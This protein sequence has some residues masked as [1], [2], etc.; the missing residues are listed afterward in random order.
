M[1]TAWAA[2]EAWLRKEEDKKYRRRPVTEAKRIYT[3][4]GVVVVHVVN[5]LSDDTEAPYPVRK[6]TDENKERYVRNAFIGYCKYSN[7][8]E[9]CNKYER[10]VPK[11]D[12]RPRNV[13][14]QRKGASS[15]LRH[16]VRC[17]FR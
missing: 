9:K 15:I 3:P 13:R 5:M 11:R 6:E 4:Q 16:T 7:F 14:R 8:D 12:Y 10:K 17:R 1:R 2:A